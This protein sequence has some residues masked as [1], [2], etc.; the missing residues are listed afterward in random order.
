MV[1]GEI[2]CLEKEAHAPARLIAD[3]RPLLLTG[4][5]GQQEAGRSR[6]GRHHDP[7]LAAAQIAVLDQPEAEL[8]RIEADRLVVIGDDHR[9]QRDPPA[10]H[11]FSAHRKA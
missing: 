11:R 3:A 10:G 9:H 1:A 8:A 7:A 4:G 2:V 5:A 6:R